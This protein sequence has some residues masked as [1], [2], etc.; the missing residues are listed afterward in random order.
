MTKELI[1][2]RE[3]S[4][5]IRIATEHI[6]TE[7]ESRT[8]ILLPGADGRIAGLQE[9]AGSRALRDYDAGVAQ[10]VFDQGAEAGRG[11]GTLAG[12]GATYLPIR[13]STGVLGVLAIVAPNLRRI[14]VPEQRR[15]LEAFMTLLAEALER[16]RLARQAQSTQ[17]RMETESLRNALLSAISHDL[18]TPLATIVGASSSLVEDTGRLSPAARDE[19][20]RTIYEE[21]LR[22]STLAG[23]IL[24]MARLD[25]GEVSF[26][27]QWYPI[28][29]IVGSVMG[30]L[31][32]RLEGRPVSVILDPDLPLVRLDAVM[33]EQVLVNL[34][35]NAVKYT[36]A[37]SGI[38]IEGRRSVDG[39]WLELSVADHGPGI[40]EGE[41][42]KLFEKFY[43]APLQRERAQSGVGLGLTICRAIVQGHGGRIEATNRGT[44]G[45][46]I[47]LYLPIE[48][49]PPVPEPENEMAKVS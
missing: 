20:G 38:E 11:T 12:S 40:P 6:G 49:G 32:R 14:F 4:E 47:T 37:A 18:R 25:A 8:A 36:P 35:E 41:A 22:M 44:G 15:L 34:L 39:G 27:L 33:M 7:F 10:F 2:T 29:E 5:V 9:M 16:V 31:R 46:V 17:V 48:E 23:N 42:A 43:R 30:R 45:A 26:N 19:L 3:E 1:V 28:E 21:A 24:D 13:G